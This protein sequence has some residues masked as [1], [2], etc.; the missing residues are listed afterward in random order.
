MDRRTQLADVVM[1]IAAERGL[2]HVSVRE[3]AAAAGVS[4]GA[5][6]H[7]FR[8]KDALLLAA[9]QRYADTLGARIRAMDQ[10]GTPRD[11][12]RRLILELLPL[13]GLRSTET[14][15]FIAFAARAIVTPELARVYHYGLAQLR[16]ILTQLIELAQQSGDAITHVPAD[17]LARTLLSVADGAT[18]QTVTSREPDASTHAIAELDAALT[19][20]FPGS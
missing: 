16:S 20:V 8:S 9:F 2:D 7:Y 12:I 4:I 19:L 5:V 3:V 13:D 10:S 15:M 6:Q 14:R 18:L 1:Q 17:T 11:I